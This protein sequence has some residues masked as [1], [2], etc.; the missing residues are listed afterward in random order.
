LSIYGYPLTSE[1]GYL[2]PRLMDTYE[3]LFTRAEAAVAGN[4]ATLSR[5]QTAHLPVQFARLEQAKVAADGDRG[6]FERTAGGALRIRPEIEPLLEMFVR[7]CREAE[8]PRLWEWGVPPDEYLA[9]TRRFLRESAR[10][11]KA[12]G[13]PVTLVRAASPKYHGGEA[14]ALTDGCRGWEDYHFHWLG[15]EGEEMEATVDLGAVTPVTA[16]TTDF[17]QDINSWVFMPSR[18]KFSLSED[19][20]S[21]REVGVVENTT[22]PEQ[23]GAVIAPFEV[24]FAP[25]PARYV[26]VET[27]SMKSCP[28]WHKGSGGPAWIFIDE[29]A[30][31]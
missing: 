9:S 18:V 17:L 25:R 23:W 31:R 2:S 12:L 28:F 11:H 5:V 22:P 14:A 20:R 4:P 15:F 29:I 8:I 13:R 16:V 1:N 30:V 6:C 24:T 19:G 10:P 7:R 26:R 3:E 21:F 27:V